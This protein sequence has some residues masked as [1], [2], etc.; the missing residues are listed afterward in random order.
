MGREAQTQQR[1][2]D[3][4]VAGKELKRSSSVMVILRTTML[5]SAFQEKAKKFVK[6]LAKSKQCE[7]IAEHEQHDS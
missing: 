5:S 4:A 1:R 2:S 3:A 7:I 6:N